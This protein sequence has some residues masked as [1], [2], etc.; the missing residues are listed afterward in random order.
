MPAWWNISETL[1]PIGLPRNRTDTKHIPARERWFAGGPYTVGPPSLARQPTNQS[2][3]AGQPAAFAVTAYGTPAALFQWQKDGTPLAGQTNGTLTIPDATVLDAGIYTAA[4][5]DAYGRVTSAG[6]TLTVQQVYFPVRSSAGAHGA[7]SPTGA[8]T[9]GYGLSTNFLIEAERYYHIQDVLTNGASAGGPFGLT[10]LVFAYG[11]VRGTGTLDVVFAENLTRRGTPEWW[12]AAY[13]LTNGGFEAADELDADGDGAK[14][15][16]EQVAGTDPTNRL[17][18]LKLTGKS[19]METGSQES[20]VFSWPSV[21]DRFYDLMES[22]DLAAG[23]TPVASN[24]PATPPLNT[25]TQGISGTAR[26]FFN[27]RARH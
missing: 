2:V 4:I 20:L 24:L 11:P 5:S 9:V 15:W 1:P 16:Q 6:A 13:G 14:N 23:F 27:I 21:A 17:S 18:V 7:V 22:A 19:P 12:L 3:V 8:V 26:G 10:N 25:Y